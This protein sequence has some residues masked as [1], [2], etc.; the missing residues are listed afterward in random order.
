M[1]RQCSASARNRAV[2]ASVRR[3]P[4]SRT[5]RCVADHAPPA[6]AR[7]TMPL[8]AG[9]NRRRHSRRA[10][11]VV[12]PTG[13][14]PSGVLAAR[15]GRHAGDPRRGIRQRSLSAAQ[16]VAVV[17]REQQIAVRDGVV[18]PRHERV[19][20]ALFGFGMSAL[21]L[22]RDRQIG[23]NA[24]ALLRPRQVRCDDALRPRSA[25]PT[26]PSNAPSVSCASASTGSIAS[27]CRSAASARSG[28]PHAIWLSARLRN[29]QGWSG[30]WRSASIRHRSSFVGAM[31]IQQDIAQIPQRR[32]Q[33][34]GQAAA[35]G[36]RRF[37]LPSSAQSR[38]ASRRDPTGRWHPPRQQPN[39]AAAQRPLPHHLD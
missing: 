3:P 1:L 21:R 17:E 38:A 28:A 18:G 20:A 27:A 32:D 31:Q 15:A 37:R 4:H 10:D 26:A 36:G 16:V 2:T 11:G 34:R 6:A 24:V 33:T 14:R 35:L 19:A 5:A 23:E 29:S 7:R 13:L 22:Q 9:G 39:A 8:N 12:R 25:G 30:A